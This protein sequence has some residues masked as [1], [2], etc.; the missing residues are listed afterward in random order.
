MGSR[1]AFAVHQFFQE[2]VFVYVQTPIITASD[3]EG[4]GE[5]FR[6]T[7]LKGNIDEKPESD[8]F[9]KPA[10]LTVSGQLEGDPCAGALSNKYPFVPTFPAI[11][12]IH[13]Y[14]AHYC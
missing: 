7:A 5:M 6:V 9:A 1:L 10:S 4:A 14:H 3:C 8:F 2:R 12:S 11:N 13:A